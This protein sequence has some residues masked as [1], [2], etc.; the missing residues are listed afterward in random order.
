MDDGILD[1]V[2][3]MMIFW[4]EVFWIVWQWGRYFR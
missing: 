4:G 2:S 1:E 3:E